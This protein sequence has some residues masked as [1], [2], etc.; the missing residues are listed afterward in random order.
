MVED[1]LRE[2]PDFPDANYVMA[3]HL[4]DENKIDEAIEMMETC[5]KADEST[6]NSLFLG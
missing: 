5:V 4:T 2:D 3:K 6:E 1:V